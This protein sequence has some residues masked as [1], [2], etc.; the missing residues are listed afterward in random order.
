MCVCDDRHVMRMLP[1]TP[2]PPTRLPH[3]EFYNRRGLGD[4][5]R[6]GVVRVQG[7]LT[8]CEGERLRASEEVCVGYMVEELQGRWGNRVNG[9]SSNQMVA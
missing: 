8:R 7:I 4:E 5:K 1:S 2:F 9:R 3:S 6:F